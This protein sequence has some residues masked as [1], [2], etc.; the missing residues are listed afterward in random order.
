MRTVERDIDRISAD[1]RRVR[2]LYEGVVAVLTRKNLIAAPDLDR[3]IERAR[4]GKVV[5]PVD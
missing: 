1:L 5:L 4:S 3:A 2:L